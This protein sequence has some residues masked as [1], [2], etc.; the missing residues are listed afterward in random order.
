MA[1]LKNNVSWLVKAILGAVLTAAL[2]LVLVK[3]GVPH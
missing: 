1:G 2:G 3:G